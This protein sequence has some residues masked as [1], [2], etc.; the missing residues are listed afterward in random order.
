[1]N[2]GHKK[3]TIEGINAYGHGRREAAEDV[4]EATGLAP[5]RHLGSDE[6]DVHAGGGADDEGREPASAAAPA[7]RLLL[8]GRRTRAGP[9]AERRV[10]C[11]RC[12]GRRPQALHAA[13]AEH[14]RV[15]DAQAGVRGDEL[16][17]GQSRHA[18]VTASKKKTCAQN[19]NY[20]LIIP[21]TDLLLVITGV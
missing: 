2:P 6:D 3:K 16:R 7:A 15:R 1:L 12:P 14:G 8:P 17:R 10:L 11:R 13:T 20:R 18:N 19:K 21:R 5:W 4:A 9:H